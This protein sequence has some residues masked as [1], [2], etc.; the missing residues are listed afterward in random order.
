MNRGWAHRAALDVRA[1][2]VIGERHR[3]HGSV[4]FRKFLDTVDRHTPPEVDVH[5]ILDDAA[6]HKTPLV[7]RWLA[8]RPRFR[9]PF[10]PT[11]ASWLNLVAC[12]FSLLRAAAPPWPLPQHLRTGAGDHGLPRRDQR[13]AEPVRLDE[14]GRRDPRLRCRLLPANL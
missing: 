10:T 5:L 12:W 13:R 9:V 8:K 4:E 11:S 6:I 14:H 2:T 3:R 7:H 1:G